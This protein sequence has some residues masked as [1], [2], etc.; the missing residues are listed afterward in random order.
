MGWKKGSSLLEGSMGVREKAIGK[1]A[2]KCPWLRFFMI[3]KS[4]PELPGGRDYEEVRE[5]YEEQPVDSLLY[6]IAM[7]NEE[8]EP[9]GF[10]LPVSGNCAATVLCA[11]RPL[12]E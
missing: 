10:P 5:F 3:R 7:N 1:E 11:H 9:G 4:L 12:R 6:A 8:E 2:G